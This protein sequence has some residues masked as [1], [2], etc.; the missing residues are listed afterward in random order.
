MTSFNKRQQQINTTAATQHVQQQLD[1]CN[2]NSILQQLDNAICMWYQQSINLL[3]KG[4]K[5]TCQA[6]TPFSS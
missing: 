3:C 1:I 6:T 5:R 2:N 4:H